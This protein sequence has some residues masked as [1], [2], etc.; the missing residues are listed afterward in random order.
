MPTKRIKQIVALSQAQ[1]P[2]RAR[3]VATGDA[4]E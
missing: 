3:A 4:G 1:L 2:A